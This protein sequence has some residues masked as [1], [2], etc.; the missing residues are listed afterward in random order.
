MKIYNLK[1]F[2]GGWV[3][4]NFEPTIFKTEDFEVSVKRYKEGEYQKKH[5]HKKADE[6]SIIVQG[7]ARMNDKVYKKDDIVLVSKGESTDFYPLE[8][9]TTTC[10]IKLPSVVGDKY[11]V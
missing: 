3:A 1:D 4:G 11:E 7:S 6:L 10:V 2:I 8:D 9:D 5:M